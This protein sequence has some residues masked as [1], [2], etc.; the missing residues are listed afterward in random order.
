[1]TAT[2]DLGKVEHVLATGD[3]AKLTP[4]ERTAYL[5]KVCNS[6]SLNP[7]TRPFQ[8]ITL[9]G[10]LTLYATRDAADQLRKL[11]GVSIRITSRERADDLCI[12]QAEATD[13]AG[14][15]D[16]SL[17]VLSVRGLSGEA[18]AN[19]LMKCETKAKRRVTLSICGLGWLDETEVE[20][21]PGV[22]PVPQ[23]PLPDE[24]SAAG[25]TFRQPTQAE[26][27]RII[28]K[29]EAARQATGVNDIDKAER[30][31][32]ARN[33]LNTNAETKNWK[34]S[35]IRKVAVKC[36]YP[37]DSMLWQEHHL[38]LLNGVVM[39]THH[40][41]EVDGEWRIV[42]GPAPLSV[43]ELPFEETTESIVIG[44]AVEA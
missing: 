43:D 10:R 19:A 23:P 38:M 14:R 42:P 29:Q 4:E 32:A 34:K 18:L 11:H 1:M 28:A 39:D 7:Y 40:A 8:Y 20:T 17:G 3:L 24:Q 31:L 33:A 26:E 44:E 15:T 25:G 16:T 35:D 21:V 9:S 37:A 41:E 5:M 22:A 2:S 12:V 6:L 36:G 30:E 13:R 27:L